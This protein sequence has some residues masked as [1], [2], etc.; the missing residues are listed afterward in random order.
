MGGGATVDD[1]YRYYLTGKLQSDISANLAR[2][3]PFLVATGSGATINAEGETIS[4]R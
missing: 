1:S 2:Q 3:V 4:I